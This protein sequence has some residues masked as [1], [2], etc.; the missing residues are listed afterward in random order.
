MIA[1]F[2][3]EINQNLSLNIGEVQGDKTLPII[4]HDWDS[5]GDEI[6]VNLCKNDLIQLLNYLNRRLSEIQEL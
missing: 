3:C 6:Q 1:Q 5:P 4:I 2:I